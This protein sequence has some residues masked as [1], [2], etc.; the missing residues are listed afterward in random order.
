[1]NRPT[2]ELGYRFAW[3]TLL[4]GLL[5]GVA[6]TAI[7]AGILLI[8]RTDAVRT[9]PSPDG[10]Y[11]AEVKRVHSPSTSDRY[12]IW[13]GIFTQAGVPRGHVVT[14]PLGWSTEPRIDWKG[15]AVELHF[16][17]GGDIRVSIDMVRDA[18]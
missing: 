14:I 18:R 9:Y 1:M 4:L 11:A 7:T 10:N 3:R 12:E 6:L 15:D 13:L 5:A 2:H 17:P 8:P 16:N